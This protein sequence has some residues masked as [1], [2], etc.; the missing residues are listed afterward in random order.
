MLDILLTVVGLLARVV[1]ALTRWVQRAPVSAPLLALVTGVV[2]GP[3]MLD[4]VDLPTVVEGHGEL[5]EFSRLLLAISVMA[6]ALRHGS[7]GRAHVGESRPGDF[8]VPRNGSLPRVRGAEES[9]RA[10]G[11]FAPWPCIL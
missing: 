1:A 4:F 11:A 10:V 9:G 3:R 6:V 8:R 5:H 2:V 7:T